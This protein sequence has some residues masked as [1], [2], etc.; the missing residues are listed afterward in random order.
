MLSGDPGGAGGSRQLYLAERG[1]PGEADLASLQILYLWGN[2]LSGAI[3][4]SW[5]I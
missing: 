5:G 3:P 1:D 2:E 4:A